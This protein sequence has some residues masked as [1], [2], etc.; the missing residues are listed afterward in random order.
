MAEV[1]KP[2]VT[3]KEVTTET[4]I[5][6]TEKIIIPATMT[7]L[8]ASI[9]L[10]K[11]WDEEENE[12]DLIHVFEKWDA[13]DATVAIMRTLRKV[14]GWVPGV[15]VY[16]FFGKQNP[17]EIEV[18]V[19]IQDG[20][21]I[22]ETC[23][24][25]RFNVNQW[26]DA[27]CDVGHS[28]Q[29]AYIKMTLKKKF[30]ARAKKFFSDV[31]DELMTNSIFRGKSLM[32]DA[33]DT[34]KFVENKGSH[35]IILNTE[36][37]RV[38]TNLIINPLGKPGKRIYLFIGTYGTGKTETAMRVGRE[39]NNRGMTF[40]YCKDATKFSRTLDLAKQ[41]SP[42]I[43]F[44]EDIDEIG[45]GETRDS[46]MNEILNTLDGVQTKGNN[47][48][49]IFTTNHEKRINKALR[50]PGR[51]DHIMKFNKLQADAIQLVY[52]RLLTDFPG[53]DDL[54]F[55]MLSESTPVIQGAVIAEICKR[56]KNIA[57]GTLEGQITNDIVLTA[58]TSMNSQIEFMEEDPEAT[59]SH[60]DEFFKEL[61]NDISAPLITMLGEIRDNQ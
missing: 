24:M 43:I 3:K 8:D 4:V 11:Q 37:E 12:I 28:Q 5:G 38:L 35:D 42:A 18:V 39:G 46:A 59:V 2:K 48:T 31:Q 61:K 21:E 41:Y 55:K 58:I 51:I 44:Q 57:E 13:K 50:R 19:D 22:F 20:K 53:G 33:D 10:K 9:E 29:G 49:V 54:D 34:L 27:K 26:D 60:R 45:S 6:T 16:T 36:E 14:L 52:E 23:F 40:I 17:K 30:S 25:G 1:L 15:P 56:S 47:I 32:I 7:K